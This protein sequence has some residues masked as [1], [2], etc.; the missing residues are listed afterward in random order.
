[1]AE[2]LT[3]NNGVFGAPVQAEGDPASPLSVGGAN[4]QAF[5]ATIAN[6][7]S[8]SGAIDLG[9]TRLFAIGMDPTAWTAAALTFKASLDGTNYF[10]L[11]DS[12]G[13]ALSWA[14]AAQQIV[15]NANA[16]QWLGIRYIKVQSGTTGTPVAQG[17]A[18]TLTVI[19]VP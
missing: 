16:A 12:T 10:D 18:R 19:G 17:A 5:T 3:Q 8:L 9:A 2:R 13:A 14:V 15:L 6:G 7:Q 1:M 11:V 4:A